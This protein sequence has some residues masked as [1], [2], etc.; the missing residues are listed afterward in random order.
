[1]PNP[2]TL[3]KELGLTEYEA[4]A[5]LV[6]VA[7]GD[8]TAERV[9]T[10]AKIPLPRVYDTMTSLSEKGLVIVTKTRPQKFTSIQPENVLDLIKEDEQKK[11]SEKLSKMDSIMPQ[12]LS[13]I[14]QHDSK[15][16]KEEPDTLSYVKRRVSVESM[17]DEIHKRAKNK[18]ILFAGDLFW[19]DD[20]R[21][22]IRKTIKRGV[23]Y[24]IIWSKRFNKV[25]P[26]IK[27][28]LELGADMRY[29]EKVGPLR[30][31]IVDD[32]WTIVF[33]NP[34]TDY[35]K[36]NINA[37]DETKS[38]DFTTLIISNKLIS[39]TFGTYF[40]ILWKNGLT[41]DKFFKK[42]K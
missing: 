39:S 10:L 24:R 26:R 28:M 37:E 12:I 3:L 23:K 5:Y 36:R 31:A 22:M 35:N 33:Q 41:V 42:Y 29:N 34:N 17:W 40:D 38:T 13:D 11:L 14:K 25:H 15:K 18:V 7:K 9:S 16:Y 8:L 30:G 6:L 27:R 32:K 1:M 21:V 20:T 19:L 4:K 2:E